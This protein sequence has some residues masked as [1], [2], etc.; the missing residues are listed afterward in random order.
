[1]APELRLRSAHIRLSRPIRYSPW[2]TL[3]LLAEIHIAAL[4]ARSLPAPEHRY[5]TTAE[6][7]RWMV[8]QLDQREA[9]SAGRVREVMTARTAAT[10]SKPPA[11][12]AMVDR[13]WNPTARRMTPD[14]NP[15]RPP[16]KLIARSATPCTATR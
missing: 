8:S 4:A 15:A 10:S 7:H 3:A 13:M 2:T 12:V 5:R 9:S 1:M 14:E 11:I 6:D 16:Q